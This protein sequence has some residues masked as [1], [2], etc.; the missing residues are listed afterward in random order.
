MK[1]NRKI[2]DSKTF[3]LAWSRVVEYYF[4]TPASY[5]PPANKNNK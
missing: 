5:R 2:A 3:S 1:W 4:S